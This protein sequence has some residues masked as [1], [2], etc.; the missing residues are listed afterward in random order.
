MTLSSCGNDSQLIAGGKR[1]SGVI[2]G[3]SGSHWLL[4][5]GLFFSQLLNPREQQQ[6]HNSSFWG[7]DEDEAPQ[8]YT[9][10]LKDIED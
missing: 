1:V 2:P 7:R 8:M 3:R 10:G 5:I 4:S 9:V 6:L